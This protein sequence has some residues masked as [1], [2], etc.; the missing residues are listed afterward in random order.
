MS[1]LN[2]NA[3]HSFAFLPD[4]NKPRNLFDRSHTFK[5]TFDAGYMIPIMVDEVLPGDTITLNNLSTFIRLNPLVTP[6]MDDLYCELFAVYGSNRLVWDNSKRFFGEQDNPTDSI[7]Y[8]IPQL[9]IPSGGFPEGS[10]ADYFGLPTK[11]TPNNDDPDDD[12]T[13]NALPFRLANLFYNEWVRDENLQNALDVPKGDGPDTWYLADGT[14]ERYPLFRRRKRKDYI[15]SGTPSL[16]KG[17]PVMLPLGTS[18]P[19][20]GNG[21]AIGLTDGTSTYGLNTFNDATYSFLNASADSYG[22]DVGTSAAGLNP[23]GYQ[24][25]GLTKDGAYSGLICDLSNATASDISQ[26]RQAIQVQAFNELNNR[27]GSKYTE[28]V[29]GHFGVRSPDARLQRP[30]ILGVASIPL[31]ISVVPQ[32]SSTDATSPQG[33]LTSYGVFNSNPSNSL[34]FS[35]SFT[36]HG[37]VFIFANVRAHLIYQ[38]GID[39]MWSRKTRLDF[40]WP[41]LSNTSDQAILNKEVYFSGVASNDNDVFNYNERYAE[42]RYFPSKVTGL[43]RSNATGTL[44]SYH[45]AQNFTQTPTYSSQFIEDNPPISRALAIQS[46]PAFLADFYFDMTEA[47]VLPMFGIPASL[48]V[49]L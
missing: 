29:L 35:H 25:F 33:N 16:Q 48:G 41:I 47:R 5:T 38:Q 49:H 10:I 20:I 45:F 19:V 7:D 23:L 27:F 13:V 40:A 26:F 32:S 8:I 3:S 34:S 31:D 42:Y 15:T 17:D 18:A 21:K 39:R 46:E 36:E 11:V 14:T 43:F 4:V 22:S 24:S 9:K 12:E 30:E 28:I 1:T 44:D 6:I 37:Y 2:K